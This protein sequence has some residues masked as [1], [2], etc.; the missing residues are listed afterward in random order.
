MQARLCSLNGAAKKLQ[1][2]LCGDDRGASIRVGC[3]SLCMSLEMLKRFAAQ[4]AQL[5]TLREVFAQRF[6]VISAPP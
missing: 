2:A 1:R 4:I 5:G 3:A 6:F